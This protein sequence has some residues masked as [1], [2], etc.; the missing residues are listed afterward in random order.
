MNF[1]EG[2]AMQ[3]N[4]VLI[5]F[6]TLAFLIGFVAGRLSTLQKSNT[7]KR[8]RD[9]ALLDLQAGKNE[10]QSWQERFSVREADLKRQNLEIDRLNRNLR[11]A[12]TR[13][14]QLNDE[15]TTA[16]HELKQ[17]DKQFEALHNQIADLQAAAT[18]H[19]REIRMAAAQVTSAEEEMT[20]LRKRIG[21]IDENMLKQLREDVNSLRYVNTLLEQERDDLQRTLHET[22]QSLETLLQKKESEDVRRVYVVNSKK[23]KKDEHT[24]QEM[25]SQKDAL[26]KLKDLIENSLP[27]ASAAQKDDLKHINGIGPFIEEKLN[28]VGIY[29]YEQVSLLDDDFIDILTAAI[30]FFSDRIKRGRWIEQARELWDEKEQEKLS[31]P[32]RKHDDTY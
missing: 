22:S 23:G 20:E 19:Q 6:L 9:E 21:N 10:V 5:I 7:L 15:L 27:L 1:L 25:L 16:N 13:Y 29:T 14:G 18:L 26:V 32:H 24:E 3:E 17:T 11:E 8:E 12:E 2:M 30:G 28:A 4:I 31:L